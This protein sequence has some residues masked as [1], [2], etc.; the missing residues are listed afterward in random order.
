MVCSLEAVRYVHPSVE[1]GVRT[2][3]TVPRTRL[4][5][6]ALGLPLSHPEGW[7]GTGST[8]H[9]LE[10]SLAGTPLHLPVQGAGFCPN[11]VVR[12]VLNSPFHR[13]R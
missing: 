5:A 11:L 7:P 10:T 4:V 13:V 6:R 12:L 9:V 8:K 1:R 2:R 3:Q